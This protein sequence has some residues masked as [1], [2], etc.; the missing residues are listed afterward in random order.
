MSVDYSRCLFFLVV[1][2]KIVFG[3]SGVV[4]FYSGEMPFWLEDFLEARE[5][6]TAK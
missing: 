3:I 1:D 6:E 5:K 4:L 2:L